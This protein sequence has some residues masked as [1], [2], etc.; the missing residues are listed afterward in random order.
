MVYKYLTLLNVVCH[1]LT[2]S[3]MQHLSPLI[4]QICNINWSEGSL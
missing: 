4:Q 3:L 2:V 1:I